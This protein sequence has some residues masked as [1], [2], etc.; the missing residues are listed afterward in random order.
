MKKKKLLQRIIYRGREKY[1]LTQ[2]KTSKINRQT[3]KQ[4]QT[5]KKQAKIDIF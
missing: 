2:N 5:R 4:Q 1:V 3:N